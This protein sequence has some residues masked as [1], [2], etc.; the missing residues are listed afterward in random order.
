MCI[1]IS[2]KLHCLQKNITNRFC[3]LSVWFLWFTSAFS[4]ISSRPHRQGLMRKAQKRRK[5]LIKIKWKYIFLWVLCLFQWETEIETFKLI[6]SS[7][8]HAH[9]WHIMMMMMTMKMCETKNLHRLVS[10]IW[11]MFEFIW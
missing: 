2:M 1:T 6:L 9:I 4:Q 3:I 5:N 8:L 10:L 7:Y 11:W